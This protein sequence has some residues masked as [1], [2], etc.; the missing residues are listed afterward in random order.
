MTSSVFHA[1]AVNQYSTIGQFDVA[2]RPRESDVT[3]KESIFPKHS[4]RCDVNSKLLYSFL[5]PFCCHLNITWFIV[6]VPLPST[7]LRV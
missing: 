7:E 2:V 4:V 1:R 3:A 6:M 5:L